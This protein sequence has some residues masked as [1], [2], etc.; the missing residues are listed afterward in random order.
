MP[1]DYID[2]TPAIGSYTPNMAKLKN[3]LEWLLTKANDENLSADLFK[4]LIASKTPDFQREMSIIL[5]QD[6]LYKAG[7]KYKPDNF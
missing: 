6:I 7:V 5:A 2:I 1:V 3:L 4:K